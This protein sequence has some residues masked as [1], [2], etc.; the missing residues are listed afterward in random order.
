MPFVS[1]YTI[2]ILLDHYFSPT[3]KH[4]LFVFKGSIKEEEQ[5]MW[6]EK[7]FS[8]DIIL[9]IFKTLKQYNRNFRILILKVSQEMLYY[10]CFFALNILPTQILPS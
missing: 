5:E 6:N 2:D 7:F 1:S 9:V 10:F 3:N 8:L 4:R